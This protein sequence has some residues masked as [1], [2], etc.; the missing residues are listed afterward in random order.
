MQDQ[1]VEE[2][3]LE[4]QFVITPGGREYVPC[5]LVDTTTQE[6]ISEPLLR[7]KDSDLKL[8]SD[9]TNRGLDFHNSETWRLDGQM[10]I[11][12][13]N[14]KYEVYITVDPATE[15]I[16][17]GPYLSEIEENNESQNNETTQSIDSV[18]DEITKL[19]QEIKEMI[20]NYKANVANLASASNE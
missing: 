6:I 16:I 13:N 3:L 17:K 11:T 7:P 1:N 20:D 19:D 8:R 9:L 15:Q 18:F 5:V 4:G 12:P 2:W 10:V 14:K